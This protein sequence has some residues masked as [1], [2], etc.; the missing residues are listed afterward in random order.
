MTRRENEI[1][2]LAPVEYVVRVA[3]PPEYETNPIAFRILLTVLSPIKSTW[4]GGARMATSKQ[5]LKKHVV[6]REQYLEHGSVWLQRHFAGQE[7]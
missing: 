2:K 6:T 1:R 5:E 7:S 4:L 3:S